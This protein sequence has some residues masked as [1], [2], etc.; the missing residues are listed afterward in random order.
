[1]THPCKTDTS[2]QR[3]LQ[4]TCDTL[5]RHLECPELGDRRYLGEIGGMV[6]WAGLIEDQ[7][8]ISREYKCP[9]DGWDSE[10]GKTTLKVCTP[11][12]SPLRFAF[13]FPSSCQLELIPGQVVRHQIRVQLRIHHKS[14]V[15][16]YGI[17][18]KGH[19]PL[20]LVSPSYRHENVWS[21]LNTLNG[22]TRL[23]VAIGIV[24]AVPIKSQTSS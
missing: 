10:E 2:R 7:M 9:D 17:S 21:Y 15:P 13:P 6:I 11:S 4:G 18:N 8:M 5:P 22:R 23:V 16:L 14:I 3:R 12:T 20:S 24:S 1:M 19:H